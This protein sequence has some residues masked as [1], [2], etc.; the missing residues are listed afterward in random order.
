MSH[1]PPP[2]PPPPS[3]GYGG[4]PPQQP[5]WTPPTRIDPKQLKPSRLWYALAAIPII[6]GMVLTAVFVAQLVGLFSTDLDDLRVP[7]SVVVS[8]DGGDKRGIYSQTSSALG[9]LPVAAEPA[10]T[11]RD[12][13]SERTVPVKPSPSVNTLEIGTSTYVERLRFKV[14]QDGRYAVTCSEPSG[15]RLAVGPQLSPVGFVIP[16][17]GT[18]LS[19]LVGMALSATIGI[20]VA[21]KRSGH[22]QRLKRE[23]REAHSSGPA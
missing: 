1:P 11:V 18:S 2:P 13:G 8:L 7:G 22:K 5:Q 17:V 20:V 15:A 6:I 10:C 19:F 9:A 21:L 16:I 4:Y 12:A 23:A 14:P 3:V